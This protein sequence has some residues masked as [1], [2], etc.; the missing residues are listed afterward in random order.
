MADGYNAQARFEQR[1]V[2][3]DGAE[4]SSDLANLN[5]RVEELTSSLRAS[6]ERFRGAGSAAAD[7]GEDIGDAGDAAGDAGENA[8]SASSMF[9]KLGAAIGTAFAISGVQAFVSA[10]AEA[11][12]EIHRLKL[13]MGVSAEQADTLSDAFAVAGLSGEEMGAAMGKWSMAVRTMRDGAG[14]L[15]KEMERWKT[16]GKEALG[17]FPE[18]LARVAREI[19]HAR[20][21]QEKLVIATSYFGESG[22]KLLPLLGEGEGAVRAAG[23]GDGAFF[24]DK[25]VAQAMAFRRSMIESA[26]RM[27]DMKNAIALKLFPII[28]RIVDKTLPIM[29]SAAESIASVF[30]FIADHAHGIESALKGAAAAWVTMKAVNVATSIQAAALASGGLGAGLGAGAMRLLGGA[31]AL[32]LAAGVGAAAWSF[33]GGSGDE[34]A[35]QAAAAAQAEEEAKEKEAKLEGDKQARIEME[36]K[37]V[38]DEVAADAVKRLGK[39]TDITADAFKELGYSADQLATDFAAGGRKIYNAITD[40]KTAALTDQT[41]K[42]KVET[43]VLQGAALQIEEMRRR[44]KEGASTGEI[45]AEVEAR[46]QAER[47]QAAA[48]FLGVRNNRAQL[49]FDGNPIGTSDKAGYDAAM[50]EITQREKESML[51]LQLVAAKAAS[52]TKAAVQAVIDGKPQVVNHFN[53][54]IT[55]TIDLRGED[56]DKI[57][58]GITKGLTE[59]AANRTMSRFVSVGL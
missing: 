42:D 58:F 34:E 39:V 3:V 40:A 19:E 24:T 50:S 21:E 9:A 16:V 36:R 28:E 44:S 27:E 57:M 1:F 53:G 49:D 26:D 2:V 6:E 37:R 33:F 51:A 29:E 25:N 10:S 48:E 4:T 54:P 30:G 52:E 7:A 41:N 46:A 23:S 45:Q 47:N 13:E 43:E 15:P 8:D 11:F 14:D 56:P 59:M 38:A 5:R 12:A 35:A 18:A 32:G 22:R 31:G 17:S 20:T 55:N